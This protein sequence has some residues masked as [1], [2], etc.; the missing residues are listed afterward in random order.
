MATRSTGE[1]AMTDNAATREYA[2]NNL[3]RQGSTKLAG[4]LRSTQ[5]DGYAD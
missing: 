2:I 4:V 5:K 3:D 1:S